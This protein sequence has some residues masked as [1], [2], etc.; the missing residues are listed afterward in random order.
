M[1]SCIVRVR[2]RNSGWSISCWMTHQVL[3]RLW[4]ARTKWVAKETIILTWTINAF[5]LPSRLAS[6]YISR[7]RLRSSSWDD[8]WWHF[9]V[10]NA[11][12]GRWKAERRLSLPPITMRCDIDIRAA[13]WYSLVVRESVNIG[14]DRRK[15]DDGIKT[16]KKDR[17]IYRFSAAFEAVCVCVC[18]KRASE[19]T[20][21]DGYAGMVLFLTLINLNGRTA[22][23]SIHSTGNICAKK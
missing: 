13:R 21:K 17:K 19:W 2:F 10:S 23:G 12:G 22:G 1:K 20:K 15:G 9:W 18:Y 7:M 5:S 8:C 3:C 11:G 6:W 14:C 4:L 16:R